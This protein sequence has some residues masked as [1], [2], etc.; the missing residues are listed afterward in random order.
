MPDDLSQSVRFILGIAVVVALALA[1]L[2]IGL[3]AWRWRHQQATVRQFL[4]AERDLYGLEA[5]RTAVDPY[6]I[7]EEALQLVA[8]VQAEN[9]RLEA[10]LQQARGTVTEERP[11]L[12][13]AYWLEY[14]NRR[15]DKV[16]HLYIEGGSGAGKT[17]FALAI[18]TSRLVGDSAPVAVI[19]VKP[20]DA[21]GDGY[22]YR[23]A[24]R[25][26][27]LAALLADVRRR[28]DEGDK[29]GLTIVLDDVTRLAASH[30]EAVELCR[31]VADVG[32]S[33]RVRLILLADGRL[34]K[35]GGASGGYS[36]LDQVV[37]LTVGRDHHRATLETEDEVLALDTSEVRQH[38]RPIPAG[39]WWKPPED[40]AILSKLFSQ[41]TPA[42]GAPGRPKATAAGDTAAAAAGEDTDGAAE[43]AGAGVAARLTPEAIQTLYAVWGSKSKIAALLSG[44][45]QQ[46]LAVID[47][48]LKG[49]AS[50][51][52]QEPEA[53]AP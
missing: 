48:A 10:A 16:P 19:G 50:E 47:A 38:A 31:E 34:I 24:E 21:W 6:V 7:A 3:R 2:L 51:A 22:I 49:S 20:D 33:L 18:L 4:A 35:G 5:P 40:E 41:I 1:L 32:R 37:F 45:A 25:P 52:A 29:G 43:A 44:T 28:L 46:R 42:A 11:A 12:P 30:P 15:P 17:T 9:R 39:R 36:L 27:A 14:V 8:Q 26:A 53:A 13:L 23:S